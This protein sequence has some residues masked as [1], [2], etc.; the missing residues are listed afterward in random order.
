MSNVIRGLFHGR[1]VAPAV[2]CFVALATASS[3][4]QT[5]KMPMK[6]MNKSMP[7]KMDKSAPM[8]MDKSMP[9]KMDK[10]APMVSGTEPS[11]GAELTEPPKTIRV[12][13]IMP[14]RITVLKLTT[15]TGETIPVALGQQK[16]ARNFAV[17]IP[18]LEPDSYSVEWQARGHD[19]HLH[20]RQPSR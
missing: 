3:S 12:S 17:A 9:M 11:N 4:A 1:L 6:P 13:F 15:E 16:A 7:M 18:E 10:S 14:M 20:H 8:K 19:G 2:F 5:T